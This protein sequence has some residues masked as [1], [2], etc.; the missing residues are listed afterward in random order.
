MTCDFWSMGVIGY[1]LITEVT[2]FHD[3]NVAETYTKILNH[4][5]DGFYG[6]EK[7]LQYPSDIEV[8]REFRDFIDKLVTK[9][10][11]RLTFQ[12]I[13]EH[14]FFTEINWNN[15]R[16][17]VPP[18]IP[19]VSGED[20]VSNFE[21]VDKKGKRSTFSIKPVTSL[22]SNDF[23]GQNLPYIGYSYV[24]E[25]LEGPISE[26]ERDHQISKFRNQIKELQKTISEQIG[27]I[28]MLQEDLLTAERRGAQKGSTDKILKETKAELYNI[29]D[30]LKEKTAELA[31]SR[32]EVK[33]L[34]SSLKIEED[35]KLKN[36]ST[37]ADVLN[38]T[39]QK[40]EKAKKNSDQSYE[41]QIAEKK[42]EISNL[43]ENLRARDGEL[44]VKIEECRHLQE[45][46][47]NYKDL[48]KSSKEQNSSDRNDFEKNNR[49]QVES[50]EKK[51]TELKAKLKLE[52][53]MVQRK[54]DEIKKINKQLDDS[55]SSTK[56]FSE[57]KRL[58]DRNTADIK[59]RLNQQIDENKKLRESKNS[60]DK[61]LDDLQRRYDQHLFELSKL[62]EQI[63]EDSRN[64]SPFRSAH[65]SLQDLSSAL[66]EQLRN[67]LQNA[68]DCEIIQRKRAEGLEEVIKRL[69]EVIS[70][71][72][73]TRPADILEKQNEK[74]E[75]KL[76]AARE[77]AIV[78]RQH[79]RTANLSLWKIEKQ[80]E[81]LTREKNLMIHRLEK[82]EE[83]F[84]KIKEEKLEIEIRSKQSK[85]LLNEREREIRELKREIENVR[86][87]V[88]Q[89]NAMWQK[90]EKERTKEKSEI[91]EYI[92][93]IH[94]HEET[95]EELKRKVFNL[96][97]KNNSLTVENKKLI[98]EISDEKDEVQHVSDKSNEKE[99]ELKTVRRNFEMLKE[100][101]SITEIQLNEIE[102]MLDT[103][104]KR[105][106]TNS[107]K[108]D[109]L[110]SK[111]REKDENIMKLRQELTEEK[112]MKIKIESKSQQLQDELTILNENLQRLQTSLQ[113]KHQEL[114]SKTTNLYEAQEQLETI[115]SDATNLQRVNTNYDQELVI[116]KEENAKVLTDLYL[117]KEESNKTLR[118][119]KD[120]K[121]K[122]QELKQE[123][124]HL[125]LV[126]AEQKSYY[127]QRDIKAEA[128]MAQHKKLN[129]YLQFRVEELQQKKKKN[130][131]DI[132]FGS[133]TSSK[134]ENIAPSAIENSQTYKQIQLE[135]SKERERSNKL[136]EQLLT[137]KT[138]MRSNKQEVEKRKIE[139][140]VPVI[141]TTPK[142][143]NKLMKKSPIKQQSHIYEISLDSNGT[144]FLT[145]QVC[146]KPIVIG[147]TFWKCKEC[148]SG[149][150]RKCR[151]G[152]TSSCEGFEIREIFTE[153]S[154]K[155][156][157]CG[158]L[159][160]RPNQ[161]SPNLKINTI[162]EINEDVL[163]L[164][165]ESGLY[166]YH[167]HNKDLVHITG[168]ESVD[169]IAVT[170]T[171][172]K[173]ILI[174]SN[175]E[176]LYQCDLRHLQSRG[177]ASAC[178]KPKLEATLLDLPFANRV[179]SERWHLAKVFGD[180]DKL[181]DSVVIAATPSRI[182]ILKFDVGIN[183]FK[184]VRALDTAK[185]VSSVLFTQHT[186]I[187]S[188]DKFFEIDLNSFAPEEFL[189]M[190]DVSL[191][192][193]NGCSPMAA[194][195]IN[196]QEFLIC[197]KEFGIFVDEYGCR[198]RPDDINWIYKP[199]EFIYREP[200]L[201]VSHENMVQVLRVSKS[202]SEEME[203]ETGNEKRAFVNMN[204]PKIFAEAG[205]LGVYVSTVNPNSNTQEII[206]LDAV[207]AFKSHLGTSFD[208][209]A[210]STYSIPLTIA[211]SDTLSTIN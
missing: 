138:E 162:F 152:D 169:L 205:K 158:E 38:S 172:A 34:K 175:G 107:D 134:K 42:N 178:L 35:M 10:N 73:Q 25:D 69:E 201:F 15:L 78:E 80:V 24:H 168:I 211:S 63:L 114:I 28:K 203:S 118:E 144:T 196:K 128:T 143:E 187:V 181:S 204:S 141:E 174:G 164:G 146:S 163:L 90:S 151:S 119:L 117:L 207:K 113:E 112:S 18:I 198:S 68:K 202:Y 43:T 62:K 101:C 176:N 159:I 4:C 81:D 115:S 32:T 145:C 95:I 2:P 41:K 150:H 192:G 189:D 55:V 185:A 8:T 124:E 157:Y 130:F 93:K 126:M 49:Q 103:E 7:K 70:K 31:S 161:L 47:T 48:L 40:W 183:R 136:K 139:T 106:K 135:L 102:V 190:S 132:L 105:N 71:F 53:E 30:K 64:S 188:S 104:V 208:T 66:E 9:P 52:K 194:F 65:G 195:R 74:L 109:E 84:T 125:T 86:K 177:Q 50:Y 13:T 87:E 92:S 1:E 96:E 166:S 111:L 17:Q 156:E 58:S 44:T 127:V 179:T 33:T 94:K 56:G 154:E 6:R 88:K 140:T 129:E 133:N 57:V 36:D 186:A 100:A 99:N 72:N 123:I 46:V 22:T 97:H 89:E 191:E 209:L 173:A 171:L 160:I 67:D 210:S 12:Q 5:E 19:S 76:T 155:E 21:D 184:P 54:E 116:L 167:L 206:T 29:K 79:A 75:D 193:T 59:L 26:A 153:P 199:T 137:A 165:C 14:S 16:N 122:A 77:E 51:I 60:A 82:S 27:E 180:N 147:N 3:D 98:N 170:S 39:Y 37:I 200:I 91:V 120:S 23:S 148:H 131:A 121:N 45:T 20:D 142:E 85:E 11:K 108:I 61:S 110:W 182:V 83:K 149:I 197:F